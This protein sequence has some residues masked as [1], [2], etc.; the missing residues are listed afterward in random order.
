MQLCHGR[1]PAWGDFA[2]LENSPTGSWD[3]ASNERV[4]RMQADAA[5]EVVGRPAAELE[6]LSGPV[7]AVKMNVD[8]SKYTV[9][10][11]DGTRVHTCPAA[12][13]YGFAGGTTDG[14]GAFDFVQGKNDTE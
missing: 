7:K 10:R 8:M 3:W 14:P 2:A 4:A 11:K 6:K 9:Y 1:G 12:L 5:S 13:G